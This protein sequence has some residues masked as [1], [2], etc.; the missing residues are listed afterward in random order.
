M[1]LPSSIQRA[2]DLVGIA[3]P[4]IGLP[5][6]SAPLPDATAAKAASTPASSEVFRFS[7]FYSLLCFD[8]RT[9]ECREAT[10]QLSAPPAQDDGIESACDLDQPGARRRMHGR[11]RA[12][13]RLMG[14]DATFL[15]QHLAG[16][17]PA[18]PVLVI[19]QRQ[20]ALIGVHRCRA[21]ACEVGVD[22]LADAI[23]IAAAGHGTCG[24]S[25]EIGH[26][27]DRLL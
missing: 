19:D 15:H 24:A 5:C 4:I 10:D 9:N 25:V 6:A 23:R 8:F 14:N 20:P 12:A 18:L 21:V 3:I 11:L 7:M 26:Q 1:L 13:H 2:D 27:R 17:E 22:D 16:S